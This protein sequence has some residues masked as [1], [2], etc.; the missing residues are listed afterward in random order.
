MSPNVYGGID[1]GASGGIAYISED[2]RLIKAQKAGETEADTA[3]MLIFPGLVEV[4]IEKVHVMPA[5][6]WKSPPCPAC[7]QRKTIRGATSLGSFMQNYGVLRGLLIGMKIRFDEVPP[8]TWQ[9][10]M[11]CLT[12]GDKNI[13]K[14][15]A[16]QLFPGAKVT[17]ATADAILIAEFGRLKALGKLP[18]PIKVVRVSKPD[19]NQIRIPLPGQEQAEDF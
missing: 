1:P 11:H 7:G 10:Y 5:V 16:Q 17:H 12:K 9:R 2:G 4:T 19:P 15:K 8:A 18:P 14:A 13:S 6:D 3:S